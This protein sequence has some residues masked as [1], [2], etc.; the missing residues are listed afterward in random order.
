MH[1][2]WLALVG[3]FGKIDFLPESTVY[4]RQHGKMF[5]VQLV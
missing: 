3:C 4:Y 5:L 2:W 1:D